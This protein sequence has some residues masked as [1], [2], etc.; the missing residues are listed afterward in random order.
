MSAGWRTGNVPVAAQSVSL[1][2]VVTLAEDFSVMCDTV[3][4]L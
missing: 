4:S 3:L 1:R 2:N